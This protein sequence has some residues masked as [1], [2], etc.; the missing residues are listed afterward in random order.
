MQL[1]SDGHF[2]IYPP[3]LASDVLA[4]PVDLFQLGQALIDGDTLL[5]QLRHPLAHRHQQL[6]QLHMVLRIG[7][8]KIEK[9][10]D[11][12]QRESQPLAAQDEDQP[13]PV[14]MPVDPRGAGPLRRDQV[15]VLVKADGPRRDPSCL[16]S[17]LTE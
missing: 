16:A 3:R 14:A 7:V 8:V 9:L 2:G 5:L 17:W 10:L 12:A 1:S 13:G 6:P 11:L 4:L 15:L